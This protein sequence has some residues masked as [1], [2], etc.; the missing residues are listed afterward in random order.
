MFTRKNL[1]KSA[2]LLVP[3]LISSAAFAQS[4]PAHFGFGTA[5]TAQDL[6]GYYSIPP[7]GRGLPAGSGN[8]AAGAKIFAESCAACH[9]DKLQGNPAAG[10]G[11]DRLLGG[12]GS[13]ATKTPVKTV[14][15]FWPYATTLFDYVKRS[16]PFSAPGSLKDDE[17]YAVVAYILSE[18]KI[19]KPTEVMDAKTLPKVVM[20]NHDGFIPDARPEL[21]L[22]R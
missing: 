22:Y 19:I 14:E 7:D 18:A 2:A 6:A 21:S 16:M 4:A 3:I 1:L 9:G 8:A 5:V 20:P 15:S 10:I 11:G 13:L 17:I 12:R